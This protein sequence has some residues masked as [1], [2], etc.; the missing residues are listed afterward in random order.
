MGEEGVE[1]KGAILVGLLVIAFAALAFSTYLTPNTSGQIANSLSD[2]LQ[3]RRR[4][5]MVALVASA[6]MVPAA[7]AWAVLD[8]FPNSGNEYA[9]LFQATQFSKGHL[10]ANAPLLGNVFVPFR[11]WIING[12][13]LSQYPPGPTTA[14]CPPNRTLDPRPALRAPELDSGRV[15]LPQWHSASLIRSEPVTFGLGRGRMTYPSHAHPAPTWQVLSREMQV[16]PHALPTVQTLQQERAT[17][18][19]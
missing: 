9:Y 4:A 8:C 16:L 13:W 15:R 18:V 2:W 5:V 7:V 19:G 14:R 1:S 17:G 3:A 12:K 10:W 11:T 6:A